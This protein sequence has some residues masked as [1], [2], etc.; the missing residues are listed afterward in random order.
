VPVEVGDSYAISNSGTVFKAEGDYFLVR[1]FGVGAALHP[2][3]TVGYDVD[4]AELFALPHPFY[5]P[6][7]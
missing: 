1:M 4:R 5:P 6:L 7:R 2:F 3:S